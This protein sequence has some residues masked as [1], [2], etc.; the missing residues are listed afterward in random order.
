MQKYLKDT[1]Y[2]SYSG[3]AFELHKE[4]LSEIKKFKEGVLIKSGF[5]SNFFLRSVWHRV[6]L[7]SFSSLD[8]DI[9]L[10]SVCTFCNSLTMMF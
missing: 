5:L 8:S 10:N 4:L 7:K 9:S 6:E 1:V 2:C 3:T